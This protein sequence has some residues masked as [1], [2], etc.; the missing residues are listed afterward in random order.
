MPSY[1]LVLRGSHLNICYLMKIHNTVYFQVNLK[2]FFDFVTCTHL[3]KWQ[4]RDKVNKHCE[5]NLKVYTLCYIASLSYKVFTW[6]PLNV[7]YLVI[8]LI[9]Y[10]LLIQLARYLVSYLLQ[11]MQLHLQSTYRQLILDLSLT[12]KFLLACSYVGSYTQIIAAS[13]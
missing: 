6:H 10:Q 8:Q 11:V 3:C 12:S 7:R 9:T 1:N 4:P 13:D 5:T 2:M